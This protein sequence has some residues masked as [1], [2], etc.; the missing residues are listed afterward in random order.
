[1]SYWLKKE[2]E[3]ILFWKTRNQEKNLIIEYVHKKG[4][5]QVVQDF[6]LFIFSRFLLISQVP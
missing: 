4:I 2:I 1:M 6:Q 3:T 5:L